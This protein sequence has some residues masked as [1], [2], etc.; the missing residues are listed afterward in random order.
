VS[1]GA[2]DFIGASFRA[3]PKIVVWKWMEQKMVRKMEQ[4]SGRK[5]SPRTLFVVGATAAMLQVSRPAHQFASAGEAI[6]EGICS[7]VSLY[8]LAFRAADWLQADA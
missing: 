7:G 2:A 4:E 8:G 6:R 5:Y 3:I 1:S